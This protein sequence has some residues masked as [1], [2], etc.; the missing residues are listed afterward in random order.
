MSEYWKGR[1]EEQNEISRYWK[2]TLKWD[3]EG[4]NIEIE[5]LDI[6]IECLHRM[7]CLIF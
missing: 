5:V 1:F 3:V 2:G 6:L 4:L 7:E